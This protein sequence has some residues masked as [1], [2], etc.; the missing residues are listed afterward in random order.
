[1]RLCAYPFR[2]A[3][4]AAY[5]NRQFPGMRSPASGSEAMAATMSDRSDSVNKAAGG[6][7]YGGVSTTVCII[8]CMPVAWLLKH[9][10]VTGHGG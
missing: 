7:R 6:V 5:G 10:I 1:M 9:A 3:Q 8:E 2:P 4:T